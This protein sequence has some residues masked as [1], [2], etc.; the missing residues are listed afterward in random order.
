MAVVLYMSVSADGY[1]ARNDNTV[2]YTQK[3][4]WKGYFEFCK[5][6]K[7]LVIGKNTYDVMPA[8]E[9][10]KE[11]FY[12]VLTHHIPK[13]PKAKNL[14]F[15]DKS[16]KE[17]IAMLRKKGYKNIG[18]GGGAKVNSLFLNDNCIDELIIDVEP[19]ILGSGIKIFD[20]VS[21]KKLELMKTTKLSKQEIQL[22]YKVLK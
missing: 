8:T 4:T 20:R 1:I 2:D 6:M 18:V 21:E 15:T 13:I 7:V 14:M 9:F 11:C 16:P 22:H 17:I 12:V 10:M 5:S 19:V 3:G